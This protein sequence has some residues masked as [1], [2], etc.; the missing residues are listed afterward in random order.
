M[1]KKKAIE[2]YYDEGKDLYRKRVKDPATGKWVDVYGH[3]KDALR[4]KVK[5]RQDE[6][7]IAAAAVG[8]PYVYQYAAKW[9]ALHTADVGLKR[10][11]DYS[12]AI[13]NHICPVIGQKFVRDVKPD[14]ILEVMLEA[15]ELSKSAQGKIV[16]TLKRIFEAAEDN[17]LLDRNPCRRLKAGG[18]ASLEKWPLTAAQQQA[19]IDATRGTAAYPFIML[20]LFC[21]L[22]REEILGLQWECIHLDA[23]PPY[24]SVRR[25]LRWEQ[26]QPIINE[27]LKSK[28]ASRDIPIPPQLVACLKAEKAAETSDYVMHDTAGNP[29]SSISFRRR[30]LDPIAA[31]SART[32]TVIGKDGVPQEQQLKVGDKVR[33]HPIYI[34]IDFRV[35]P[36]LLRHTYITE[37]IKG[38]VNIK[39]VQYLAGHQNVQLTLN[40]YAHVMEHQ[41]KDTA[42]SVLKVF[43][44]SGQGVIQGVQ[45]KPLSKKTLKYQLK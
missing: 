20:G 23:D 7:A 35:T 45:F 11:A 8:N 42:T 29:M 14:D 41:P 1:P 30:V 43:E 17:G 32:I 9:Y 38:G 21:G 31:R 15:S 12:N 26:N 4:Q 37:L 10:Q 44:N 3:T 6:L 5:D 40:I 13:N 22:R 25:A 27:T 2:F 34:T 24:L 18:S 36:H 39:T 19:L 33:N 28:A 16:T